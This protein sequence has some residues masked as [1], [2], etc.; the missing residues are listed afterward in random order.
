MS[1]IIVNLLCLA[2]AKSR[3]CA[4]GGVN[5]GGRDAL[6]LVGRSV[7]LDLRLIIHQGR[8]LAKIIVSLTSAI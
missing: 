3:Y 7:D 8:V 1:V 6:G 4:W 5:D 2:A